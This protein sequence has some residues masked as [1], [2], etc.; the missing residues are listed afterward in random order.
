MLQTLI[1]Y[2][3][4]GYVWFCAIALIAAALGSAFRNLRSRKKAKPA[5][6]GTVWEQ[7]PLANYIVKMRATAVESGI[8]SKE[9][10]ER[11]ITPA[12]MRELNSL[13]Q[14]EL[15]IAAAYGK[16]LASLRPASRLPYPKATI[17][18]AI[19]KLLSMTEDHT[20][21][22]ILQLRDIWDLDLFFLDNIIPDELDIDQ[23]R[24]CASKLGEDE[25]VKIAFTN[26]HEW[27]QEFTEVAREELSRRSYV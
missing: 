18:D 7:P 19:K 16:V 8:M 20:S 4:W 14:K 25:L 9:E 27:R 2:L 12:S 17:R 21:S 13:P 3:F 6:A 26:A 15:D 24:S 10:A 22:Y 23:L 11:S 5:N 1:Y